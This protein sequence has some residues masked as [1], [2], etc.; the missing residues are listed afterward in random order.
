M[1]F[2]V[3]YSGKVGVSAFRVFEDTW[4]LQLGVWGGALVGV[5]GVVSL[6]QNG[7]LNPETYTPLGP[8]VGPYSLSQGLGSLIN[9]FNEPKGAPFF[10]PGSTQPAT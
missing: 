4:C 5:V 2:W 7:P 3:W 1:A 8:R 6:T 10:V 9:P